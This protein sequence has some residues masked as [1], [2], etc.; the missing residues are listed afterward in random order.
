LGDPFAGGGRVADHG[1]EVSMPGRALTRSMQKPLS[2]LWNVT[3]STMP[4]STSRS[5]WGK[6]G[7][8]AMAWIIPHALR[9]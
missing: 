2:A 9:M 8:M 4:A 3:R 5:G 1:R 6:G 7:G